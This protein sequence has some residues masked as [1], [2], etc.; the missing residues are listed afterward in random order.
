MLPRSPLPLLVLLLGLGLVPGPAAATT[1]VRED[2]ASLTRTADT[3][4]RGTVLRQASRWTRDG[5]RIVTEVEVSVAETLKGAAGEPTVRLLQPGG[6]VGELAQRVDGVARFRAGEEVV[7]FLR[8]QGPG[9]SQVVG[10]AQGKFR[11]ERSAD[12][13]TARAVPEPLGDTVLLDPTTRQATAET[14]RPTLPLEELRRQVRE[15]AA[16]S[17]PA[18]P[19]QGP[20][21]QGTP[22]PEKQP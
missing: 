7:V 9:P 22:V 3:V 16:T 4:V 10:M 5:R 21:Q 1:L 12:G 19:P 8:G 14:P 15:A 20:S 18:V 13:R 11:V 2:V 6:E 17:Q